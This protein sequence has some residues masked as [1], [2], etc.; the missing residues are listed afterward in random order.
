M[1]R[2]TNQ[3][4]LSYG[5]SVTNSNVAVGEILEVLSATKT[6]VRDNYTQDDSITYLINIVNAGTIAYNGLTLTDDLGAYD[7]GTGTP[8]RLTPLTYVDGSA[9]YFTNGAIQP[10]PTVTAGPSLII[11][12]INVP[13]GGSTLI[14][15]E[16]EV[17]EFAPLGAAD[18]ITNTAQI[19]GAGLTAP[20]TV[21]ETVNA[22]SEPLLTITK[23]ISPVP[24]TENGVLT[25]T[26]VIQNTGNVPVEADA[27]AAVRDLFDPILSNLSVS[28][29]GTAWAETT[30]YTYNEQTGLFE[31][32][33]G[34]ITV[35]AAAYTQDAATGAWLIT[36]G[37]STLIVTG[38]V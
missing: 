37:A 20:I 14:V 32:V 35:P 5:D 16:A 4:Q 34:Q 29:N 38:T 15:Y 2:F 21:E 23:S 8:Q 12:G 22:A 7:F 1:A 9:R 17:N 3:A 11:S 6:A 19:T 30:N 24:V 26:F 18:S 25:Y 13:A 33:A 31:T 28:F 27:A 10:E 36:P